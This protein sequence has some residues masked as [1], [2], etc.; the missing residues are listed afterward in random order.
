VTNP[1]G[2]KSVHL[3][4]FY[5][6]QRIHNV[7]PFLSL[8]ESAPEPFEVGGALPSI[9][10]QYPQLVKPFVHMLTLDMHR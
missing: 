4:T 9:L 2:E 7:A 8:R 3:D 1:D 10:T 5:S 6:S